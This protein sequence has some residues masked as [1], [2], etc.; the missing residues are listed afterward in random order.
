MTVCFPLR[1]WR[2]SRTWF[3]WYVR[4]I[5][6]SNQDLTEEDGHPFFAGQYELSCADSV[7]RSY[8]NGIIS[9]EV[10]DAV[11]TIYRDLLKMS[12]TD[13]RCIATSDEIIWSLAGIENNCFPKVAQWSSS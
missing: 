3:S 8:T 13:V 9:T 10:T 2:L 12:H 1:N 7:T 11:K 5:I 6:L 4:I